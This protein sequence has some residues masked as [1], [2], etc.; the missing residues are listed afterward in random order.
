VVGT[1]R[2]LWK[3]LSVSSSDQG[4]AEAENRETEQFFALSDVITEYH[5]TG[6]KKFHYGQIVATIS[7]ALSFEKKVA[8]HRTAG[9][10][11]LAALDVGVPRKVDEEIPV[12]RPIDGA[13]ADGPW[14]GGQRRR[15][16][17]CLPRSPS[18]R[19][20]SFTRST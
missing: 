16:G 12:L 13:T 18:C 5:K 8:A 15:A 1:T 4:C 6:M 14:G 17:S 19:W 11:G 3:R 2:A 10:H 7:F 9:L 20:K